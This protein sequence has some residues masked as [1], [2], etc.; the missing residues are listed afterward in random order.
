M[1]KLHILIILII[2]FFAFPKVNAQITFIKP[3]SE[4][5]HYV[6][7]NKKLHNDDEIYS[8][9]PSEIN[10]CITYDGYY[11]IRLKEPYL[12]SSIF[13]IKDASK[14]NNALICK[15]YL[16]NNKEGAIKAI[17]D[18]IRTL[19]SLKKKE[20]ISCQDFKG[21]SYV[22]KCTDEKGDFNVINTNLI[23]INSIGKDY[24]A[25]GFE[26]DL[27]FLKDAVRDSSE[28]K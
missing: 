16:S 15:I 3:S 26:F 19:S 22:F 5:F 6:Y 10:L 12:V 13:K 27:N 24:D 4:G 28:W 11:Y 2:T 25:F 18:L 23:L 20:T 9:T 21:N 14:A 1:H 7:K 17:N 8:T